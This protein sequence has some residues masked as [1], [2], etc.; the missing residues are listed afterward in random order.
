MNELRS[1]WPKAKSRFVGHVSS[2]ERVRQRQTCT[3]AKSVRAARVVLAKNPSFSKSR[4]DLSL[5]RLKLENDVREC[6]DAK[7]YYST[8]CLE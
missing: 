8:V 6:L 7:S 5:L 4:C 3:H 2:R 1:V